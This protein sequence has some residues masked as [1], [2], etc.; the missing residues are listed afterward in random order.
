LAPFKYVSAGIRDREQIFGSAQQITLN[1]DRS[2][3]TSGIQ[4]ELFYIPEPINGSG[5]W[6]R[7]GDGLFLAFLKI[8]SD[9]ET[10]EV[11]LAITDEAKPKLFFYRG[12]R[13]S[14][15]RFFFEKS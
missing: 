1:P 9:D 11:R 6:K 13:R 12:D 5:T 14:G 3:T 10:F 8:G 2:F 4:R 7:I 15:Y